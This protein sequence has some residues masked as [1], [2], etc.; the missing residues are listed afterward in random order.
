MQ[1]GDRIRR[2]LLASIDEVAPGGGD[3]VWLTGSRV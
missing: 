1:T 2:N 3:P